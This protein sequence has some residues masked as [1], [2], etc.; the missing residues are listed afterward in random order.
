MR[1]LV[2]HLVLALMWGAVKRRLWAERPFVVA[3]TGS[4]GKTSTKEAVAT[5][6][7]IS[8]KPVVKTVGNL[9][10]DTGIPLSLMGFTEQVKGMAA[11]IK[12]LTRSITALYRRPVQRP[13]W[14]LEYS[15]DKPGDLA[16]LAQRVAPDVIVYTSGGPVHMEYYKTQEGV[17]AELADLMRFLKKDGYVVRNGDDP[18]LRTLIWP[19]HTVS[20]GVDGLSEK[21]EKV[22]VRASIQKLGATASECTFLMGEKKLAA[23]VAVIGKQ[24]LA[25]VAAAALVGM[26]EGFTDDQV[27]QGIKAYQIPAGRGRLIPGTKGITIVDDSANASPEAA[28]AGVRML[29]PWAH[30]RRTV[31][32][33]GN[34]NELGDYAV[35]AH[36]EVAVAAAKSVDFFVA[37]GQ[38]SQDMLSAAKE[39]GMPGHKMLGFATPEQFMSQLEQVVERNDI[40][41]IKASQNGMRLERVVKQLMANPADAPQLLVRQTNAWKE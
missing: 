10:T 30:G 26:K 25:P 37:L 15:S 13:Y 19:Q 12:V 28:V 40:I 38:H 41:Y 4:V 35:S 29:K 34:M 24:Q 39:A 18:F 5:M 22:D 8:G 33:L 2:R 1:S 31:A 23:H 7:E 17:L 9:A 16:F 36:R 21:A 6:L 27:K 14:V 20:Y 3:V 32:V 11:W